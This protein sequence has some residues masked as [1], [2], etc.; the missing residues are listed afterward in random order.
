MFFLVLAN[1]FG[2][3]FNLSF[4]F[5]VADSRSL[6]MV[7][8]KDAEREGLVVIRPLFFHHAVNRRHAVNA[9]GEFLQVRFCI[10]PRFTFEDI[11]N[12][13]ETILMDKLFGGFIT[14]I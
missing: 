8:N 11:V 10:A 3:R 9:L 5:A 1:G 12:L 4:L 6:E 13:Y 14:L 7:V 2:G